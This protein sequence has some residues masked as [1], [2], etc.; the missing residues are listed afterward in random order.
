MEEKQIIE[1]FK[2]YLKEV[3]EYNSGTISSRIS[4]LKK[5]IL[6]VEKLKKVDF[7]K[8]YSTNKFDLFDEINSALSSEVQFDSYF[9]GN[10]KLSKV[11]N[12]SLAT[13]RNSFNLFRDHAGYLEDLKISSEKIKNES[14]IRSDSL[15][16]FSLIFDK[17][18]DII[19][20]FIVNDI[21]D[22]VQ[23]LQK[24]G[25][26][27]DK[28]KIVKEIQNKLCKELNDNNIGHKASWEK[29]Y[30]D[31]KKERYDRIDLFSE[32]KECDLKLI[33]E[34][35]AHRA[36][37]VAKK[38][39]SR[40][41]LFEGNNLIYISLCYPGTKSMSKNECMKYFDYCKIISNALNKNKA[42]SFAGIFLGKVL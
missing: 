28:S 31:E 19:K 21:V 15:N 23:G 27:G 2:E 29:E 25:S 30:R 22:E 18:I 34:L 9:K 40:Q 42:N 13:Y 7:W 33:I 20:R 37:Q 39:L 17:L 41:A 35:D 26:N 6:E 1:G 24:K 8:K 12:S 36:D 16:E 14:I 3:K 4:N 11:V 32:I 5:I 10:F 38:F